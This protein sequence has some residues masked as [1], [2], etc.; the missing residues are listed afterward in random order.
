MSEIKYKPHIK[1][2]HDLWSKFLKKDFICIDATIGNGFDTLFLLELSTKYNLKKIIGF[3]IQKQAIDN[4]KNLLKKN[5]NLE[6]LKKINLFLSSHEDFSKHLK[7]KINLFIYNLGYLPKSDKS[8]TTKS[9]TTIQS[10]K[11][12]FLHL[13]QNGA[14][15]ITVYPGHSEGKIE[16]IEILKFLEE[17]DYKIYNIMQYKWLNKKNSPFVIWIEKLST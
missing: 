13:S 3:D 8:I 14:I 10:I 9:K 11:S 15:S 16:E 7:E 2:A 12:A 1:L 6:D 5:F 4:T 17:I